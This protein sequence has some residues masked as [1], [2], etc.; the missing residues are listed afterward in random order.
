MAL[1]PTELAFKNALDLNI[2]P[3][4][5]LPPEAPPLRPSTSRRGDYST[6]LLDIDKLVNSPQLVKDDVK[7][8]VDAFNHIDEKEHDHIEKDLKAANENAK[9]QPRDPAAQAYSRKLQ[10]E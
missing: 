6:S 5:W 8:T 3:Y 10:A 4:N 1:T 7:F 9:N 2:P